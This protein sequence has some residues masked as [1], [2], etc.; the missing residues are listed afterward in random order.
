VAKKW[1]VKCW[2]NWNIVNDNIVFKFVKHVYPSIA[3]FQLGTRNHTSISVLTAIEVFL[4][5]LRPIFLGCS[6]GHY[7]P[8]YDL[9]LYKLTSLYQPVH[10]TRSYTN[11][12]AVH[13]FYTDHQLDQRKS[14]GKKAAHRT[15][16]KLQTC[17]QFHQ[18]FTLAKFCCQKITKPN[19]TREICFRTKIARVK[20]WWNCK[21]GV[22]VDSVESSNAS[23]TCIGEELRVKQHYPEKIGKWSARYRWIIT[24][25]N[26]F[27]HFGIWCNL[28]VWKFDDTLTGPKLIIWGTLVQ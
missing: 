22:E 2:W 15:L 21:P 27:Q 14:T 11:F 12:C 7:V 23:R 13:T 24:N 5:I 26:V 16:M 10:S 25:S 6:C 18:R 28:K 17:R 3:V 4:S 20:C 8:V 19:V 9:L 1:L